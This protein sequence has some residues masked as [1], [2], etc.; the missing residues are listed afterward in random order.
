MKKLDTASADIQSPFDS[1]VGSVTPLTKPPADH[2][3]NSLQLPRS[4]SNLFAPQ[5]DTIP[6]LLT[7][8]HP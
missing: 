5:A 3:R 8:F 2:P 1:M 6:S 7:A 4:V